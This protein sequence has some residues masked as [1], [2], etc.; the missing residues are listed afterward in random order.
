MV[1]EKRIAISNN[2]SNL[3]IRSLGANGID[4]NGNGDD[5]VRKVQ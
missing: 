1:I 4:E 2:G 3:T 5:L